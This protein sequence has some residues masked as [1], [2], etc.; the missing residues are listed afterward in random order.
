ML[1][2]S[3]IIFLPY[4]Y[5]MCFALCIRTY[6][7]TIRKL[8]TFL[9]GQFVKLIEK[10]SL[11]LELFLKSLCNIL[12]VLIITQLLHKKRIQLYQFNV[13]YRVS[14][15]H[16]TFSFFCIMNNT[17]RLKQYDSSVLHAN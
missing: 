14:K 15:N 5:I 4:T 13:L 3:V 11:I 10:I 16:N 8:I 17:S 9:Q 7:F 2:L 6:V 1:L 12:Y